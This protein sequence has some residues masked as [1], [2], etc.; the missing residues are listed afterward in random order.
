[1]LT[2]ECAAHESG[3][4]LRPGLLERARDVLPN[5]LDGDP[6]FVCDL[7]VC[8]S[9]HKERQDAELSRRQ[10]R[11]CRRELALLDQ[12]ADSCGMTLEIAGRVTPVSKRRA[13][14]VMTEEFRRSQTRSCNLVGLGRSTW[15]YSPGGLLMSRSE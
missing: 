11:E 5:G 9:L 13:A 8:E 2:P 15:R 10:D 4:G 14:S 6:E 7:A 12:E 3:A 1:V